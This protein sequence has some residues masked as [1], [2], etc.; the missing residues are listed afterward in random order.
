MQIWY[1]HVRAISSIFIRLTSWKYFIINYDIYDEKYPW[2]LRLKKMFCKEKFAKGFGAQIEFD[3]FD[4][5]T[6]NNKMKSI[7]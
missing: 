7:N 4:K 5:C 6:C 3:K 1:T 2:I